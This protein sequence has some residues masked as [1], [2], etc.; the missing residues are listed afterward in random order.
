MI[1]HQNKHHLAGM[2]MQ[3]RGSNAEAGDC[4][5]GRWGDRGAGREGGWVGVGEVPSYVV[6]LCATLHNTTPKALLSKQC[7]NLIHSPPCHL[8]SPPQVP[9]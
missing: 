2:G 8:S 4:G 5:M 7:H 9:R 6:N 1:L 3:V